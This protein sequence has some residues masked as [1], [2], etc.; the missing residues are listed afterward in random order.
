VVA[1]A[2]VRRWARRDALGLFPAVS[3]A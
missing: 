3:R 2:L 1:I